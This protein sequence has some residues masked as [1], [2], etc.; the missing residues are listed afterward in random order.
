MG[1]GTSDDRQ[2]RTR[3][4][5]RAGRRGIDRLLVAS[6]S[7]WF[8]SSL[9]SVLEPRGFVVESV[10]STDALVAEAS[11]E[12]PD[13]VLLDEHLPS[14]DLA[15]AAALLRDGPLPGDV[16]LVV[17][18]SSVRDDAS[19]ARLLEA[20][21]WGIVTD[22][23][24]PASLVAQLRRFLA[25]GR[26]MVG[27]R[28]GHRNVDP[29]TSL[30]LLS[31]LMP[32]VTR[33][34]SLASRNGAPVTCTALGPTETGDGRL[35]EEQRRTVADLCRDNL[36]RSDF[37]GWLDDVDLVVVSYGVFQGGAGGMARRLNELLEPQSRRA[38]LR[39]SL[40]AGILE[41]RAP[42]GRVGRE[43]RSTASDA[44][45]VSLEVETLQALAAAQKALHE[46]RAAGG[47]IRH[48]NGA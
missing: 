39:Y 41:L 25:L 47:G 16:P 18:T 45:A 29:E 38:E 10:R 12:T 42:S 9:R 15:S 8:V 4:R 27:E 26:D 19:L 40:S 3:R 7:D 36:R 46:A 1:D 6:D 22:P 34:V 37:L 44:A 32:V 43:R 48:V 30:L 35:R 5:A 11:R 21:A 2:E 20:G 31:G 28:E 23:L 13:L 14:L 33:I 17:H 24:R